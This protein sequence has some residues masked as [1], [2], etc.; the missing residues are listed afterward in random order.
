[1]DGAQMFGST[2][3]YDNHWLSGDHAPRMLPERI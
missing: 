2:L 1:M 3:E